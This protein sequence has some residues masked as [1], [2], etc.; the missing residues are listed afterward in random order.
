MKLTLVQWRKIKNI[1][2]KQLAANMGVHENTIRSWEQHPE[3][4]TM[5]KAANVANALGVPQK[6]IIFC[7][8]PQQNVEVH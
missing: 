2:Q 8:I 1:S 7:A 6:N 3:R 4:L 5:E